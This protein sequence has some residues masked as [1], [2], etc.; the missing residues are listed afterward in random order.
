MSPLID[1]VVKFIPRDRRWALAGEKSVPDYTTGS[2]LFADISGF[3]T[4]THILLSQYGPKRGAEE[5]LH[6]I[7]PV[8]DLLIE[9][10]H[11]YQGNVINF[12]GDS[13]TCWFNGDNGRHGVVCAL[14]MQEV[15]KKFP[16]VAITHTDKLKIAIK[17]AVANGPVRRFLVG[18]PDIQVI[19][20][21]AGKTVDRMATAENLA[22]Q[23]EVIVDEA[24][25]GALGAV[26]QIVDRRFAPGSEERFAV[27]EP[28]MKFNQG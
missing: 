3:S 10:V 14:A 9:L 26:L 28:D 27:S 25:A 7:N 16:P 15:V 8:Y 2:V 4:L 22:D 19:D 21:L 11:Q 17:V 23:G 13:I 12:A 20:I 1:V 24:I 6:Q 18:N 5:V